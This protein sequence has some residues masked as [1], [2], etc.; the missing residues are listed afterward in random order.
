MIATA[1]V[2]KPF[3]YCS[4]QYRLVSSYSVKNRTETTRNAGSVLFS[5]IQYSASRGVQVP[6]FSQKKARLAGAPSA[7]QTR[8]RALGHLTTRRSFGTRFSK[9]GR[10]PQIANCSRVRRSLLAQSRR[11][12]EKRNVTE[13]NETKRYIRLQQQCD[14]KW[15]C[16]LSRNSLVP[17]CPIALLC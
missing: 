3:H 2:R 13:P 12:N 8:F 5:F 7:S 4:I 14:V 9:G 11:I 6:L 1:C 17:P 10:S 16:G 15:L